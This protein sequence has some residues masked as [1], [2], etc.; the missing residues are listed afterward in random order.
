M[1]SSTVDLSEGDN[2]GDETDQTS[3]ENR[4][5][6]AAVE[7]R[8]VIDTETD[9]GDCVRDEWCR[10]T[11][12]QWAPETIPAECEDSPDQRRTDGSEFVDLLRCIE[13][14]DVNSNSEGA[15]SGDG[16][17]ERTDNVPGRSHAEP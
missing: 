17:S 16:D 7:G 11:G 14:S 8:H 2:C 12:H 3:R 10:R 15:E 5:G 13:R 4:F 1:L 9:E 6:L